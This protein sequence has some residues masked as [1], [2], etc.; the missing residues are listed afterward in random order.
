M[1]GMLNSGIPRESILKRNEE[2][3][4]PIIFDMGIPVNQEG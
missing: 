4:L 3:S 2:W 1:V